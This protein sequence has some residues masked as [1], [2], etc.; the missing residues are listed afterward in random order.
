MTIQGVEEHLGI[1]AFRH[2]LRASCQQVTFLRVFA[3][4]VVVL[5]PF[6][7]TTGLDRRDIH[8]EEVL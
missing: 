5:E 3:A 6:C 1:H 8:V 4:P 7:R 2:V